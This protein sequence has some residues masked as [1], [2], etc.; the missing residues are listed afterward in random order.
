M[1]DRGA[2]R[3]RRALV[4]GAGGFVGS[5]LA[6][7]L[8][9]AGADVTVVLRD[10]AASN[11]LG[12]HGV[13]DRVNT[14]YGSISDHDLMERALN[15]HEVD[16]VFHLAAQAIVGAANRA[17]VSTFDS[18]IRGTWTLLEACRMRSGVE[19]VVVAS[20]DKAYGAQPVLPYTEDMALLALN[21]YDASKACTDILARTYH[22]S[23]GLP[24]AVTRMANIYGGAD[25][26]L[27][28]LVPGTILAALAGE[29][30]VIR[31]DGT[32][33]RDY[34]FVEDAVEAFLALSNAVRRPDVAGRAFNFGT[35]TP[36]PVLELV[37]GLLAASG[38]SDL[39]PDVRGVAPLAGEIDQQ[40]LDSSLA[41]DVLDWRYSTSRE[42]GIA[43]TVAW[44]RAQAAQLPGVTA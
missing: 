8:V 38:R 5:W 7:A 14:V 39:E 37:R 31:S 21:P 33:L 19:R 23:F 24:V 16:S 43:R 25:L 12:L 18:N 28:R 17:P 29:R 2:W 1:A 6:A 20:S 15:E 41:A 34:L 26:N 42:D 40:Y 22:A 30:P 4:T 44:Y 9:E 27:S 3:G 35:D 13:D 11:A 36:T 32:P 10:R